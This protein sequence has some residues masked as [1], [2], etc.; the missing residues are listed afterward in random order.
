M[1]F[2]ALALGEVSHKTDIRTI[3]HDYCLNCHEPGGKGYEKNRVGYAHL[4]EPD[5]GKNAL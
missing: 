1:A 5:E 3:I 2:P 4:P